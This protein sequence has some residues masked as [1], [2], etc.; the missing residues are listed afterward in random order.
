M[1][2]NLQG[3]SLL[4]YTLEL[5]TTN[6]IYT[7]IENLRSGNP[8]LIIDDEIEGEGDVCVAAQ[9]VTG[10]VVNFMVTA[11]RGIVCQPITNEMSIRLNLPIMVPNGGSPA[12]AITA[13]A[14]GVGSGTSAHDRALTARTIAN[15]ETKADD[16]IRPGHIFPIIARSGGVTQRHQRILSVSR[17]LHH[18][19]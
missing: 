16:L 15:P 18:L 8:I 14:I 7:A 3:Q 10:E 6:V 11:C 5:A 12:F 1:S 2:N 9:T 4:S 19:P 13:D 17:V